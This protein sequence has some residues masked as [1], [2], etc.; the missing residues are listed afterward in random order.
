MFTPDAEARAFTLGDLALVHRLKSR[1]ISMDSESYL[2]RGLHTVGDATLS[3]LP[4]SNLG[5][6]TIVVRC[7][8]EQAFGQFRHRAGDPDS[9]IVFMSPAITENFSQVQEY[10]WMLLLDALSQAAGTRG[11]HNIHAEVDE[12]S[13]VF[14]LLRGAGFASYARQDIWRRNPAPL[15]APPAINLREATRHDKASILYLHGQIVPRLAQKADPAPLPNGLICMQDG[16][17]RAFIAVSKGNRGLYLKP[18]ML[19]DDSAIAP[20]I[21]GV[22]MS[23]LEQATRVPVFCCL[24]QYQSWLGSALEMWGFKPWARQTVMVKHTAA[25][26]EKPA[27]AQLPNMRGVTIHGGPSSHIST[28]DDRLRHCLLDRRSHSAGRLNHVVI[29]DNLMRHDC[30]EGDI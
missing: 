21:I 3:R 27:F 12:N 9:H 26:V 15:P 8:D 28:V 29:G 2:S 14:E 23:M 6:P 11:A 17:A 5:T 13:A 7:G 22:V 1:G 25:R 18:Y 30:P 20:E 10:L 24:R 16:R 19:M 4:F